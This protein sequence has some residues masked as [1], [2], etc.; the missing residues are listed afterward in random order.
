MADIINLNPHD[1]MTAEEAEAVV[2]R[3]GHKELLVLFYDENGEFGLRSSSMSNKDA[4]FLLEVAKK[5]I[6]DSLAEKEGDL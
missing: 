2:R 5:Y 1:N 6:L 3:E 4:V